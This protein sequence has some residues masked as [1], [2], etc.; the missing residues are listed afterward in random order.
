MSVWLSSTRLPM[1]FGLQTQ[2][3][4]SLS[5]LV[6]ATAPCVSQWAEQGRQLEDISQN[7]SAH[8]SQLKNINIYYY[9]MVNNNNR[10][11]NGNRNKIN[12]WSRR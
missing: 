1:V 2:A 6:L 10:N 12:N 7:P 5:Q 8:S 3:P 9:Q 11:N 4:L